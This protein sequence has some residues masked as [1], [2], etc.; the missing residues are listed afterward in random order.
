M[1]GFVS[2]R[3]SSTWLVSSNVRN[4]LAH[5]RL[6]VPTQGL[7]DD[8]GARTGIGNR[9]SAQESTIMS[10]KTARLMSRPADPHVSANGRPISQC[11]SVRPRIAALLSR[12]TLVAILLGTTPAWGWSNHVLVT[13]PALAALPAV[14]GLAPVRVESIESFLVAQGPELEP[15]LDEAEQAWQA[16]GPDCAPRPEAL[17]YRVDEAADAAE[18]RRR[19]LAAVRVAPEARLALY[20]QRGPGTADAGTA[21]RL[22]A[23]TV[24][25][26]PDDEALGT[27]TFEALAEGD[28]LAPLDV[29]ASASDEPDYGLDLGLWEDNGTPQGLAY[30]FGRQP[31]GNPALVFGSQAPFHMGF[32]HESRIIYAAASFL[33]R[34]CPAHRVALWQALAKHALRTGHD[35]W[36][37]RFAGWAVHYLQDLAQPYHAR[38][39]PDVGTVRMLWINALHMAG[40][41]RLRDEAV[42]RVSNRHLAFENFARTALEAGARGE[43]ATGVLA[44]ALG[45]DGTEDPPW[46]EDSLRKVV[47]GHAAAAADEL[48]RVIATAL[49]RRYVD[50]P[51]FDFGASGE[52]VDLFALLSE[53]D[54]AGRDALANALAARLAE[55]GRHTRA[56]VRELLEER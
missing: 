26:L 37:W 28:E 13:R 52:R 2:R 10:T 44:A 51:S 33:K 8:G 7:D 30:G 49:P 5:D 3:P 35:Y 12:A 21:R 53:S 48:D 46:T 15:V 4:L 43:P 56:F 27:I 39:L 41:P 17:R 40:W 11:A 45:G 38:V 29:L 55:A 31:F 34:T 32:W 18:L 23:T 36:G 16:Q 14:A 19:F 42:T 25:Q 24:T 50:D 6:P 9:T 22:P 47:A 1:A 20:V 54:P